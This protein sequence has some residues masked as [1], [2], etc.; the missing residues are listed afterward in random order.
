[1][2]QILKHIRKGKYLAVLGLASLLGALGIATLA[3]PASA[4]AAT[5][6]VFTS[7]SA[8]YEGGAVYSKTYTVPNTSVSGCKDINVRNIQNLQVPGDTCATFRVQFF[9][10]WGDPYYGSPKTVCSKNP[11]GS[12][13]GPVVPIATNVLDGTKYRIWYNVENLDWR[14]SFQ[15]VD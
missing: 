14:H 3:P 1:M 11:A 2:L 7:E 4:S 12:A 6:R 5:C 15:I 9:P 8:G 13:N 10:T